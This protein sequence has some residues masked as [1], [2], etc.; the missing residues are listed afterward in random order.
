MRQDIRD[1]AVERSI[2]YLLHFTR[3]ENLPS[4]MAN[5]LVP[6]AQIDSGQVAAAA[7]DDMRLDNRRDY[8]CLSVAFPNC[9][10]FYRFQNDNPGVEWPILVINRAIMEVRNVN[11]GVK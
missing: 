4:I 9:L 1:F 6:R 11:G 10:M 2:P 7:N 3:A 5:G 8:N